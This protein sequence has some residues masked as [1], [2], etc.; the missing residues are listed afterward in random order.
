MGN[1][2]RINDYRPQSK[3]LYAF[4]DAFSTLQIYCDNTAL[5]IVQMNADNEAIRTVLSREQALE[6]VSALTKAVITA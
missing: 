2:V 1:V 4:E 6:L 5:E 3:E